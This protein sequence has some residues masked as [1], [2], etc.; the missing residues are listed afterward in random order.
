MSAA[1]TKAV[2][3]PRLRRRWRHLRAAASL[4]FAQDTGQRHQER[5]KDPHLCCALVPPAYTIRQ[6]GTSS[7][8]LKLAG[9]T[10]RHSAAD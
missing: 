6:N 1:G 2:R 7:L 10:S 8:E 9:P 5:D 4:T 3:E